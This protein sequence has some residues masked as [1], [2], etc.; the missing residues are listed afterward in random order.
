MRAQHREAQHLARPF[1]AAEL[2]RAQ[3][4]VDGDE[5]AE[6]LRHLLAFDLQEAVVHPDIGHA[7]GAEGAAGLGD[8][9]LVV[10]ERRGRC[11]RRGCRR[12]CGSD[13]RRRGRRRTAR[14]ASPSTWPS[15]RYA[16]PDGPGAAMPAGLGQPGSFGFE[17]FHKH[18]VHRVALV[19]RDVDARAGQHLVERAMRERPVARRARQRVHRGGREQHVILGDIGDAAR[20][21]PLDHRRASRRYIR[22]RAARAVG[23][24]QPSAATSSWN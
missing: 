17:G 3:Q 15:T 24:R 8:L 9:V 2:R 14:A 1:A 18:E 4:L 5:I 13:R 20:D 23:G 22:W 6:A 16:S 21:Q 7:R 12:R 19:G 11:R 10:R